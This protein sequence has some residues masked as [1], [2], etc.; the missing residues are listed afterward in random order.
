MSN[1]T[2]LFGNPSSSQSGVI[3]PKPGSTTI[4]Y[5][6]T[7]DAEDGGQGLCYSIIDMSLGGGLGAVTLKNNLLLQNGWEKIT[8]VRHS[9]NNDV[10]VITRAYQS[11]NYYSWLIT[12][13]GVGSSPVISTSPNFFTG[14]L[15]VSR[16][17]LKPSSDGK[18]LFCAN[19]ESPFSEIA[20][21][22][23]SSGVITN[24]TKFPNH[25][26]TVS[27][28]GLSSLYG[29]E[30][31]PDSKLLYLS[32]RVDFDNPC[33]SC[34]TYNYYIHQY[35]VSVFDSSAILQS[36]QTIDSGYSVGN[37]AV[38][39]FGALQ[40]AKNGKIYIAQFDK[41]FLSVITSPNISGTGC[42]FL[43]NGQ[44]LGNK[45]SK[46]GFPTFIQT[47]FNPNYKVYDFDFSQ[48]CDRNLSVS[49]QTT[50]GYDSL[51]WNF[52]DIGSG[53]N[54]TATSPTAIHSYSL[55]GVRN[56]KLYIYT[57]DGCAVKKDS[58]QKA[59]SI[60]NQ[61]FDLGPNRNI[62]SGDSTLLNASTVNATSYSWNNSQ[63][64]SSIYAS[65][66]GIY[67]CE[68]VKNGCVFRD[69]ITLSVTPLPNVNLGVDDTL[70]QGQIK[71]L[72]A[73]N[74]GASYIWQD[75]STS[76]VFIVSNPGNYYVTVLLNGCMNRD[77]VRVFYK[78][79]PQFS[80]GPDLFICPGSNLLLD[81]KL[82]DGNFLWQDGSTNSTYSVQKDGLYFL[83]ITN[84]C[85]IASD[86]VNISKGICEVFFPNS[87]SPN[88]DN[89]NDLFRITH[90]E[91]ILSSNFVIYNRYG[92]VVYSSNNKDEGWDGKFKNKI[93]PTGSYVWCAAIKNLKGDQIFLSGMVTLLQ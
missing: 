59:I 83:S 15:N 6:F 63:S 4:Y 10:W 48:D 35:N 87:F 17:Y 39:I 81:P 24:I 14:P 68:V 57:N 91:S 56:I 65:Q 55:S 61:W 37:P 86:T 44:S 89:K 82:Y 21:F 11:S 9:N 53:S 54:N 75:M 7:I 66:G 73:F 76:P 72:S 71:T 77:T 38:T 52:D 84:K 23:S 31:S 79:K 92:Q 67:W 2:G 43:R 93:Q 18:L 30:F 28:Q 85:G 45:K 27:S 1:G 90:P 29:V 49:L 12:A 33:G 32:G 22:N 58:V 62:C 60:G 80:L 78:S 42:G 47:Y 16:G 13:G 88:G 70:C 64:S 8:A 69:S 74:L 40:L 41:K 50:F 25:P 26:T 20:K 34:Q 51:R 36:V 3:V 46:L 19:E 5:L